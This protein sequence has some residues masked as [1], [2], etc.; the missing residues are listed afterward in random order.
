M[1]TTDFDELRSFAME[2]YRLSPYL[3]YRPILLPGGELDRAVDAFIE[4]EADEFCWSPCQTP[5][6]LAQL[7]RAGFLSITTPLAPR[8]SEKHLLLPKL[9]FERCVIEPVQAVKISRSH[10]KQAKHYRFTVNRSFDEVAEACVRQHGYNWLG[11]VRST[12]AEL[13]AQ[14]RR[15]VSCISIEIWNQDDQ[16]VAGE[17]GT[18]VGAMY[19]SMTGFSEESGAGSVQL[20]ALGAYLY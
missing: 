5:D 3:A 18:I 4:Q 1:N 13:H 6:F 10:R 11:Y 17:L 2:A 9:H 8:P 12:L 19:T 7:V 14:P 15:G 16:L 20:V